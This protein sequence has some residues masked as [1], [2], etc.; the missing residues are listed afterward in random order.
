MSSEPLLQRIFSLQD[1]LVPRHISLHLERFMFVNDA[2]DLL[3]QLPVNPDEWEAIPVQLR[4]LFNYFRTDAFSS[5]VSA[6]RL[7]LHGCETDALALM[8]VVI[9]E[10]TI[11]EYILE[12]GLHNEAF[13]EF[14]KRSSR[15]KP[16]PEAFSYE[17]ALSAL[18]VNDKRTMLWGIMSALGSHASPPRLS[19]AFV[20]YGDTHRSRP[21]LAI[22]DPRIHEGLGLLAS[23]SLFALRVV[24]IFLQKHASGSHK[25]FSPRLAALETRYEDISNTGQPPAG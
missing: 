1:Q 20:R 19:R 21:G 2:L 10:L 24:D 17:K 6:T 9:E 23:Q 13:E 3:S 5:M 8:R 4:S 22:D 25:D 15:A 12:S 7:C 16:F 18:R 11:L 14:R